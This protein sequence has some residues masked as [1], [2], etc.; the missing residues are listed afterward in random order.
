MC[1]K[2]DTLGDVVE[3]VVKTNVSVLKVVDMLCMSSRLKNR[4]TREQIFVLKTFHRLSN[5]K[6]VNKYG[7]QQFSILL[8]FIRIK[9]IYFA[10]FI[11]F[12]T[13][14]EKYPGWVVCVCVCVCVSI[15]MCVFLHLICCMSLVQICAKL[16]S[17][18]L[19]SKNQNL[20]S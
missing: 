11:T 13:T 1:K 8:F 6:N 9:W 15:S 5:K 14:I 17:K 12:F 10:M 19:A 16:I 2:T 7:M 18:W 4:W 20:Y 3:W